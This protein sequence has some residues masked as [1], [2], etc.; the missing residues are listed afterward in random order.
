MHQDPGRS[1]VRSCDMR[2]SGYPES[3]QSKRL[4][5]KCNHQQHAEDSQ[6]NPDTPGFQQAFL[7]STVGHIGL[8]SH[9]AFDSCMVLLLVAL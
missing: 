3:L 4:V 1:G 5:L 6:D 2:Y 7:S 8:E 9:G